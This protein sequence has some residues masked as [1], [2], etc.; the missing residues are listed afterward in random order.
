[1]DEEGR[2]Y[3]KQ[4]EILLYRRKEDDLALL[5]ALLERVKLVPD[6]TTSHAQ[7]DSPSGLVSTMEPIPSPIP[8][9]I[10]PPPAH[11]YE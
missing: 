9:R 2:R 7:L 6:A 3:F 4:Q 11:P 1:M 8:A 10:A 5:G